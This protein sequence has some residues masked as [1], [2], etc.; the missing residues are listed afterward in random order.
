MAGD[1]GVVQAGKRYAQSAGAFKGGDSTFAVY[2][3]L[4]YYFA[5]DRSKIMTG[6]EWETLDKGGDSIDA[7]TLFAA[8]R[9]YF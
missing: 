9:M 5:G 6:V 2:G 8:Y 1:D 4:N 7:T 3:G